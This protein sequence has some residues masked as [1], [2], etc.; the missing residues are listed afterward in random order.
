VV[1]VVVELAIKERPLIGQM[2][3]AEMVELELQQLLKAV[4]RLYQ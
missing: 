3:E 2:L 1:L 4:P